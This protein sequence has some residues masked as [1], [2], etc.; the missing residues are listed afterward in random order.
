MPETP[1]ATAKVLARY[2]GRVLAGALSGGA[3]L[4]LRFV[5][6]PVL[7]LSEPFLPLF[8]LILL[9]CLI[10]GT[11]AGAACLVV[12]G[13]YLF[14]GPPHS[15]VLAPYEFG[16]L[17]GTFA[18]GLIIL[19]M[20]SELFRLVARANAAAEHERIIAREF[21]HRMRNTLTLVQG[22]SR[23]T[24]TPSRPLEAAR[25]DFEARLQALSAAHA[26]LLDANG[27]GAELREIA[28]RILAPF[29][30]VPGEQRIVIEGPHVMLEPDAAT[31]I[32]LALH[33]L[34]TNAVKYG[35]L[36]APGGKVLVEWRLDQGRELR[37]AWRESGGPRV[38]A[39]ESRG[40]GSQLIEGNLA[41]ALGGAANLQFA[42]DGLRAE[43]AARLR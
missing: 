36:S 21:E 35:A 16:G 43:I 3:S 12:G 1:R 26:A 32:A 10:G 24:F 40:F 22:I 5:L 9:S 13:W 11:W 29:G 31:A 33:E 25:T 4:V 7:G 30:H 6:L 38:V 27:D 17:V 34:A 23:R 14:L 39:P 20:C 28:S 2:A 37:L 8:P 19:A 42:P 15:F 18:A 41:Q